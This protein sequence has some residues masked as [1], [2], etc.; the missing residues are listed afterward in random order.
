MK[1]DFFFYVK[2]IFSNLQVI[3]FKMISENVQKKERAEEMHQAFIY[4]YVL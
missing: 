1:E 3:L 2:H 4:T